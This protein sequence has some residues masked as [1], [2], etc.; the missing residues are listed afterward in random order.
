M[1]K[2]KLHQRLEDL[3]ADRRPVP[4]DGSASPAAAGARPVT[5]GLRERAARLPGWTWETEALGVYTFCSP[6][7]EAVLGFTA[8]EMVGKTLTSILAPVAEGEAQ[9]AD[10]DAARQVAEAFGSARPISD[11]RLHARRKDGQG[12]DLVLHALPILDEAGRLAG[13]RG[14]AHVVDADQAPPVQRPPEAEPVPAPPPLGRGLAADEW[15]AL[16]LRHAERGLGFMDSTDGLTPLG[17]F[18]TPEMTEALQRGELVFYDRQAAGGTGR[19]G[20]ALAIPIQ[21]QDQ[22]IG[23]LDFFDEQGEQLWTEDDLALA[24]AVADQLALALEN[25]RLFNAT[26]DQLTKRTLL[27]DVTRAAASASTLTDALQ[28]AADVLGRVLPDADIAIMLLDLD[29]QVLRIRA[30]VGFPPELA[31]KL[32][33]PLGQGVTGR[34]AAT[35]RPALIPD[36]RQ[37]PAYIAT[38]GDLL[39]EVAVPLALGEQ[40]IGVLNV[41][42][43]QVNA[44]DE[45]D[46]QLLSTLAG[47]LSAIIVNHNLLEAIRRERE[48][49][50]LLYD[51]LQEL[52]TTLDLDHLLNTLLA[53]APRLAA[54][55]AYVL[56]LGES[57]EEAT[58]RGS[59]PGLEQLTGSEAR[60]FALTIA[61]RGL[62]RWVLEHRQPVLVRDTRRDPRWYT[63]PTHVEAEPARCVIS[64]P[65]R[66]QRGAVIGALAYTHPTPGAL[67][68]DQVPL[69]ESIARQAGVALENARLYAQTRLQQRQAEVVA[70]ATQAMSNVLE[71]AELFD[72]LAEQLVEAYAPDWVAVLRWDPAADTLTPLTVRVGPQGAN[73]EA[74][75]A[76]G[77]S[78]PAAQRL[79]LL[80][81]LHSRTGGVHPLGEDLRESLAMPLVYGGEVEGVV[82]VARTGSGP[83]QGFGQ[84]ERDLFLSIMVALAAALQTARLY[85]VQRETALRLAEVDRLKSQFLANMSHELRTPLNS[86]IG[87]SRVMLKGIDGPL[88]DLQAQDLNSIYNAG[89]HLLGLINDILDMSRIEAGK[90]ELVY[91][92]VDL[93]D[94]LKGVLSTTTALVKD[95]PITLHQDVA[96]DLPTVRADSMRVRQVMLNLLSNAAKFT[97]HGAITLRARAVEA[98]GAHS[99]QPEPFVEISVIDTGP[100]IAPHDLPKLFE[101]FSQVDASATRKAGG[102]GLGLNICRHLV[103]LHGGRIW[104]ES[105]VGRGS[106]FSFTLP[107]HRP[108]PEDVRAPAEM[109]TDG[110]VALVVD[111]DQGVMTLYRRYLEPHGYQVVGVTQSAEAVARAEE[112]QPFVILLDVL[113]PHQDGWQVLAELKQNPATRDLPVIMCTIVADRER[114][115]DLGAVDYFVK[116]ILEAELLRALSKLRAVDSQGGSPPKGDG[117][118]TQPNGEQAFARPRS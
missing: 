73:G 59:V 43:P 94:I 9:G 60:A 19:L 27:Y 57:E 117:R 86:I 75:Y 25:A 88:T 109:D 37:E 89:Q 36:V 107:V 81:V 111:D 91:D 104:V 84:D 101:P 87:F 78:F 79:D 46:V 114:A 62:E 110:P 77:A 65:L 31:E 51:V 24:Q 55:H 44:F 11:L 21:L 54:R 35:N 38:T 64:V 23:V 40:A 112:L 10:G 116:P 4:K 95:K 66:T 113:M 69:V 13:Y 34:V 85:E 7:V 72:V 70:R 14:V 90:M 67:T 12:L 33:V 118:R 15:R 2:K 5:G 26:R 103:E 82:E 98:P 96:P 68:E 61:E 48:R 8:D 102:T 108:E 22:T 28:S 42:S 106:T 63:D 32:A 3:F 20:R 6:E 99:G 47:T 58:F 76:P 56:L 41:E 53:F 17:D 100:G 29:E 115:L 74:P 92:E 71:E 97:D 39:S 45:S 83:G 105:E 49:L 1:P 50:A 80:E 93:H 18:T 52:T 30:S 16:L